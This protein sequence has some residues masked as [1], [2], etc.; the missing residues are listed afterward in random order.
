MGISNDTN[1]ALI[2]YPWEVAALIQL[3]CMCRPTYRERSSSENG[4]FRW[5]CIAVRNLLSCWLDLRHFERMSSAFHVFW[6]RLGF[7]ISK[8]PLSYR[9]FQAVSIRHFRIAISKLYQYATF[10][11]FCNCRCDWHALEVN[12]NKKNNN[13]NLVKVVI[14]ETVILLGWYVYVGRGEPKVLTAISSERKLYNTQGPQTSR[15]P[16]TLVRLALIQG[17]LL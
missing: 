13:N 17:M 12:N 3:E 8:P 4:T 14:T 10:F 15:K 2:I 6:P 1:L 9:R 16:C 7:A 11:E 5:I